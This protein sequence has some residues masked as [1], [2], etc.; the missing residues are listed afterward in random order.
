MLDHVDAFF[1]ESLATGPKGGWQVT[2]PPAAV[3]ISLRRTPCH[4][5]ASSLIASNA[6]QEA[7]AKPCSCGGGGVHACFSVLRVG[8]VCLYKPQLNTTLHEPCLAN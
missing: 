3:S 8:F 6:S 7:H 4:A 5:L 2:A 1:R